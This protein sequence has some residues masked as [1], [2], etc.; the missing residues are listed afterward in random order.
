MS[1]RK[2]FMWGAASAAYQVEGAYLE[3]G[4]GPGIWDT[5]GREKGRVAHGETGDVACDHYHRYKEDVANM[6]K[7][8]IKHCRFSISWPRVLPEGTGNVNSEGLKFYSDLVDELLA[9]GITPMVTLFHWNYPDALY[10]KGGW[11]NDESSH[12]FAEYVQ[13][14]VDSLSDRV[15]YWMTFNEP[16]IFVGLGYMAGIHAPFLKCS[17][18]QLIKM[19]HNILKAHGKAVKIIR[20]SS[21]LES[22]IGM[23]PTGDCFLPKDNSEE[24]IAEAKAKTFTI[25]EH[26]FIF[27]T[28]WWSDPIFLG[29]YPKEC[30]EIFGDMM[31]T[32]EKG[33]M[34]LI[35]QPLDFYGYN[36]YQGT[37]S[38]PTAGNY[39][40][41]SYQGSPRTSMDWNVT[42]RVLYWSSKF[43]YERYN[44]PILI[45]E[46]GMAGMDWV[47]M[48]GQVHDAH[49]ID[50][51]HRYLLELKRAAE[52][53]IDIMG[54]T[55]WSIMDNFEWAMGYD[56]R[57][58]L[59]HVDY[60]TQKRT[61][62]DSGFWYKTVIESNGE[63]L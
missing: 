54:Y 10:K 36:A 6:K 51:M 20:Q 41:Y 44:K 59:I 8:G 18:E 1:F 29:K 16:Q 14:I 19:S 37:V 60:Q 25:N 62:K 35:S 33:D 15:Q 43:L 63:N 50:F 45:T 52:E 9:N 30:Y 4:K 26:N 48:D 7:I 11:L 34:E 2:D 61:I 3:D 5:L 38:Y 23:A 39:D 53:G 49:R 24:A 28:R 22:K 32:I 12:W 42:P 27:G 13:V 58:G 21:K 46:N 40:E 47:H 55:Y 57:F 56:K 31:P 17:K